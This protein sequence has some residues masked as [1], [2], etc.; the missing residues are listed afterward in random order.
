M[1]DHVHKRCV[2]ADEFT[3]ESR[4]V[5]RT[6]DTGFWS[7]R[8]R[9]V[10]PKVNVPRAK[11]GM[12]TVSRIGERVLEEVRHQFRVDSLRGAGWCTWTLRQ[13]MMGYWQ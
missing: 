7:I 1:G 6:S 8:K 12:C 10:A 2:E 5:Q 4:V 3:Q 9:R 11:I 13:M